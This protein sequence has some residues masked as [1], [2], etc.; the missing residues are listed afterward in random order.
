[1]LEYTFHKLQRKSEKELRD[2]HMERMSKQNDVDY[3][4]LSFILFVS[5]LH[6]LIFAALATHF[7]ESWG[8]HFFC[9]SQAVLLKKNG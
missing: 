8:S 4:L 3:K 1:M 7:K 9:S 6:V 2:I 5:V